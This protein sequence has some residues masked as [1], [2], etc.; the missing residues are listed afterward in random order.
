VGPAACAVSIA[1]DRAPR[2]ELADIVRAYGAAYA[3]EHALSRAQRRALHA[4]ATCRTPALGG[5]RA[6]CEACGAEQIGVAPVWWRVYCFRDHTY[7]SS[8][9]S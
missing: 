2:L 8:L 9:F 6:V 7:D 4:I 1:A 5:H 3:R